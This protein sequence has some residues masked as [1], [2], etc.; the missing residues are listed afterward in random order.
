M[1]EARSHRPAPGFRV[2]LRNPSA[3]AL[4]TAGLLSAFYLWLQ[5]RAPD[6]AAQLARADA[7]R[8]G[9]V[10]SWWTGWFGGLSLPSYS[11]FVPWLMAALGAQTAGIVAVFIGSVG[12]AQLSHAALRPRA[13]AIAF[14]AA[15]AADLADGRVTFT[16]GL[17]MGV[18]ALL[19]LRPGHRILGAGLTVLTYA[20]SPLAGLFLGIV[21]LACLYCDRA[22][23]GQLA[24]SV[25]LLL[26][27][28]GATAI[29][30]PGTGTMP[31]SL[32]TDWPAVMS[33][34]GLIAVCRC[35]EIRATAALLLV[36]MLILLVY[37]GAVGDNIT[38]LA[39]ACAVPATV[40]SVPMRA[41]TVGLIAVLLS[42]WPL[43]DLGG[44]LRAAS[45][46]SAQA[47][48]Y[49]SVAAEVR[50]QQ[51]LAGSVAVG[52]RTEVIDSTDHY[53]SVY[54]APLGLARGWD[55]QADRAN[56]PIFYLPGQLT[57]G[58][59]RAW[60]SQL[61]VRWIALPDRPLDYASQ[62][63]ARLVRAG[64]PY[65]HLIWSSHRWRLYEVIDPTPLVSGAMVKSV[66]S[67]TIAIAVVA[68]V[69]A[70]V[71]TRWSP[72]LLTVDPITHQPVS[73][74]LTN[75][76]GWVQ[77]IPERSG[78]IEVTSHFLPARRWTP[79]DSDCG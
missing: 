3:V 22:R 41:R 5:P 51:R 73:S 18:C 38:R 10:S 7:V 31:Y 67:G 50:V 4:V 40:A 36:A 70:T 71:R 60:L 57:T 35:R 39:W 24:P 1:A 44:Q 16:V 58:S 77:L 15:A 76:Y 45:G 27:T 74:C 6:L 2:L 43:T 32:L 56:N 23:L 53:A 13:T 65:L 17:S 30:F 8:Y 9:G 42:I 62:A 61:A 19:A 33:C 37:P 55:R 79:I 28:A 78:I 59:Y 46:P 49:Q 75:V 52:G 34:V 20:A 21:L 12:V 11:F 69:T 48:F 63:E 64:L 72:Y 66:S 68:G 54:L 29:L 47:A 14:A 25:L 26:V